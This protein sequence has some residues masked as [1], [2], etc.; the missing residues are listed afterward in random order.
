MAKMNPQ[1]LRSVSIDGQ[2]FQVPANSTIEDV[3]PRE[4]RSV[5][6]VDPRSGSL[7]TITRDRFNEVVPEGFMTHMTAIAKG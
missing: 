1:A 5:S 7:Q 2:T 6:T 3:V 4:V